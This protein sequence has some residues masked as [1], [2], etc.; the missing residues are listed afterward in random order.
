MQ[1]NFTAEQLRRPGHRHR[2][3]GAADLRA[4]RHVHRHL[5]DL[6]AAGRR[7]RQPARPHL[8]DQGHAGIGPAGHRGGGAP[9]RPLPV[10]PVLHDDLPV[11]RELHAP[12]RPR[13]PLYR[14]HV[15]AALAR[16]PAAHRA[17]SRAAQPRPAAAGHGGGPVRPP[18]PRPVARRQ[19]GRPVA[20]HAGPG[21][22]PPAAAPQRGRRAPGRGHAAGPRGA[23]GRL[24]AA[25]AGAVHQR[26]HDP[27]A[28]PHGL[29]RGGAAGR[30]LL[31]RADPPHGPPRPGHGR[32]PRQHRRLDRG[33]RTARGWTRSW[34][35]PPA[36]ARR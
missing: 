25:G 27:P 24:R 7:A 14:G 23:A 36:A 32:R 30:R 10:L 22:A 5:P 34:S 12:G 18:V 21:A 26:G 28:D 29:R 6:R 13:P 19:A 15:P 1:T 31:R 11:R 33:E 4:L 17:D 20:R 16:A 9:R 35:T 2:Q 3:P 8:P